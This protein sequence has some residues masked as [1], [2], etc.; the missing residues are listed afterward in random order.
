MVRFILERIAMAV[1]SMLFLSIVVFVLARLG[2]DPARML[3]SDEASHEQVVQMRQLLFL[4]RPLHE[5]YWLWL[6][7][8]L[9]GD[10]GTSTRFQKPVLELVLE[11]L[12]AT[13][14]LAGSAYVL[15]LFF[16]LT[17]GIYAAAYRGTTI[18]AVARLIAVVGQAAPS[19]WL[20][21]MLIL[22]FAV[23]LRWLPVAGQGHWYNLILPAITLGWGSVAGLMRLTRSSMIEVLGSDY[24]TLARMKGVSEFGVLWKHAFRNAVLPVMTF[25]ALV[26]LGLIR[27]SVIV[28]TVFAWPGLGR[29]VLEGVNNRDFPIVQGVVLI[30]SSWIVLGNLVVDILYAYL[31]PKIRY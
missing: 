6:S 5:Q 1:V 30:F 27:G 29:L 8:V 22:V 3:L 2:G 23:W 26:F 9:E 10:F 7:H 13:L 16:G 24:I 15:T 21:I 14:Q 11:R 28:E 25:A 4:D 20:G 12:P 31:N 19:F 18:D 17:I